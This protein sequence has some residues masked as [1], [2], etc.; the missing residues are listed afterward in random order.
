MMGRRSR[1]ADLAK[2]AGAEL[3][4][5]W[6][7]GVF[8]ALFVNWRSGKPPPRGLVMFSG[9]DAPRDLDDPL[10]DPNVQARIGETIAK[11]ALGRKP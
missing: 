10:S 11:R 7:K 6:H 1:I 9:K 2:L 5:P 4:R 3:H 8:R